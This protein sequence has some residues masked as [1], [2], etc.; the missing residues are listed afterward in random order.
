MTTVVGLFDS[1]DAADRAIEAL[2][3]AGFRAEDL[4]VVARETSLTADVASDVKA[5]DGALEAVAGGSL[6]GG[7]AG[8]LAGLGAMAIPG[9]GLILAAGPIATTL[10]GAAVGAA[11]G[12]MIEAMIAQG[13]PP[14]RADFY[15][16]ALERGAILVTVRTTEDRADAARRILAENGGSSAES[17]AVEATRDD[18]PPSPRR[19]T[20]RAVAEAAAA[21]SPGVGVGSMAGFAMGDGAPSLTYREVEPH[22]RHHWESTRAGS[23]PYEDVSHAYRYGWE[24][25]ENP[26]YFGKSWEEISDRLASGWPGQGAWGDHAPLVREAWHARGRS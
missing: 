14:E 16:E 7:V 20:E 15:T 19:L 24:S 23:E 5:E 26:D 13:I 3:A 22:F 12:G 25:Y 2:K 4:S 8:L 17:R 18:P 6:L 11:A 21:G 9:M 1:R 10:A